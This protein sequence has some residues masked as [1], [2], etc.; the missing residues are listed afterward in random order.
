[1]EAH[2]LHAHVHERVQGNES[3][4][5]E[6]GGSKQKETKKNKKKKEVLLPFAGNKGKFEREVRQKSNNHTDGTC[7]FLFL[8]NS[9]SFFPYLIGKVEKI[10]ELVWEGIL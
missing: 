9:L 2:N 8:P 4:R 5:K 10:L 7:C 1:M 6:T 3:N